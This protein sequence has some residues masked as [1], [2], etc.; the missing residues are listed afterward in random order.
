MGAGVYNFTIEQGATLVRHFIY[1]DSNGAVVPLTGYTARM[2]VRQFK[3]SSTVLLEATTANGKLVI[4]PAAGK[5]TLTVSATELN[6]ITFD[7]G[8]YDLEIESS[9]GLV[10]RLIEGTV[11]NSQQVTR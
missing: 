7:V 1:K 9:S 8:V 11:F 6:A 3:D 2:Q 5:I 4:T 10:T